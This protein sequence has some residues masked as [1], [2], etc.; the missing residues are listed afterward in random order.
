M[1]SLELDPVRNRADHARLR[2]HSHPMES[3]IR[4]MLQDFNR[5]SL[6]EQA[7]IDLPKRFDIKYAL[8]VT[9]LPQLLE[10]HTDSHTVLQVAGQRVFTYEN[11]YFDTPVWDLYRQHHNGKL[12]RYKYR[13]RYYLETDVGFLEIKVKTNKRRTLKRRIP[14]R[15]DYPIELTDADPRLVANLYVNYRRITLWNRDTQER[16]TLDYDIF[17]RR[18]D[19]ETKVALPDIVIAELKRADHIKRSAFVEQMKVLHYHPQ[20]VSKYCIGVCLTDDGSLKYNRFKGL[21]SQL[22]QYSMH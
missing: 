6:A 1:V 4:H 20:S 12:N 13:Y 15:C 8:P 11:T 7:A 3:T 19:A 18:L 22:G 17:Y 16:L 10:P 14:W 9:M 2:S 21:M 5:H